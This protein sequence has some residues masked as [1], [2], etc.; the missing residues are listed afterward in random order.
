M[1]TLAKTYHIASMTTPSSV[2]HCFD[3]PAW[4]TLPTGSLDYVV[5]R[6]SDHHPHVQYRL[7]YDAGGLSVRFRVEDCFVRSVVTEVNEQVCTDSCVELFLQPTPAG[8][9]NMEV[10]AGGTMLMYYIEDATSIPG[11]GLAKFTPVSPTDIATIPIVSSLPRV[12]D[13]EISSPVRWEVGWY[14]PFSLL[15]RYAGPFATTPGTV[16]RGN[17]YKCGDRTSHPH[18][19]CWAPITGTTFHDPA[20]FGSLILID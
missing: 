14:V 18:W 10:N 8:Y 17:L 3:D 2:T 9:F 1:M 16:W 15:A 12:I 20:S 5:P 7:A 6:S 4:V 11:K 19:L 13:P